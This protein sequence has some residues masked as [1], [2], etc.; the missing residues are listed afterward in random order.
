MLDSFDQPIIEGQPLSADV[1]A[2][3]MLNGV[4]L[5]L[6]EQYAPWRWR[7]WIDTLASAVERGE[8]LEVAIAKHDAG[9]PREAGA[10]AASALLV[11]DPAQ[12]ILDVLRMRGELRRSWLDLWMLL[13]YP[14]FTLTFA[15]AI[16][17]LFSS[18]MDFKFLEEFGLSGAQKVLATVKDQQQ[19]MYGLAFV[20]GWTGLIIGTIAAVG[21][22]WSLTAVVGGLRMFGRPLRWIN[23]SEILH[24]YALFIN[25]G[26]AT[27]DASAAVTRSFAASAQRY[28]A[29]GIEHRIA[30]GS[31]LGSAFAA[32]SLSDSLSRPSLRM[33]DHRGADVASSLAETSQL[34]Q[35]LVEQRCRSLA[36]V[37]PLLVLLLVGTI[38][39]SIFSCYLQAFMPLV[40]MLTSLA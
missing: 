23:L 19:A 24:R 37:M 17:A 34:L 8:S 25:Q 21:P 1:T 4:K 6:A 40:S 36:G 28:A 29:E 35:Y 27:T 18:L 11:G 12:L 32:T 2:T 31:S 33:L 3:E 5:R 13:L 14:M 15:V 20:V 30:Q 22:V 7:K 10:I 26:L 38:V 9:A 39:W 16:G